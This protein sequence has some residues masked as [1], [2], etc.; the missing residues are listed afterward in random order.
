[1]RPLTDCCPKPLL[2]VAGKPLIEYLIERLARAGYQRLVINTSYLGEKIEIA[3]GDGG[4][5]GVSICYSR[6]SERL[7]TAGGIIQA[8]PE[9]DDGED[10]PFAVING[11]IWCDYPLLQLPQTFDGKAHLILVDNPE[12]NP[13]GDF[14]LKQGQVVSEGS[15]RLTFAGISLLRPSLFAGHPSGPAPLAPLL[16]GAIEQREVSGE[17]FKGGW[18]DVGT[19]QRLAE[20]DQQQRMLQGECS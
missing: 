15:P 8:L 18:I 14:A 2:P 6:E 4:R 11:D 13:D 10:R 7:E 17:H 1:M 9:L 3:L 16:R 12:H 20:L 19:P 5:W